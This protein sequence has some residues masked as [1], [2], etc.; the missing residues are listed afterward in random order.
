MGNYKTI[1]YEINAFSFYHDPMP[2]WFANYISSNDVILFNCGYDKYSI[3]KAFCII[4]AKNQKR[5]VV[6]PGEFILE[7]DYGLLIKMHPDNF[8]TKYKKNE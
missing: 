1:E 5:Q 2:E 3:D 7:S 8:L 6:S 4:N